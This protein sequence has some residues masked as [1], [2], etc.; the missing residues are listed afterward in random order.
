[1]DYF[2]H[3]TLVPPVFVR[4]LPYKRSRPIYLKGVSLTGFPSQGSILLGS[5]KRTTIGQA[6][7]EKTEEKERRQGEDRVSGEK[8][9]A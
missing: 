3:M 8:G 2:K 1:M 9:T 4:W 7:D 6:S 5:E